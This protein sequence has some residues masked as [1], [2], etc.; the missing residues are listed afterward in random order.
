MTGALPRGSS[1]D[2]WWMELLWALPRPVPDSRLESLAGAA[3][4]AAGWCLAR[5]PAGVSVTAWVATD[6]PERELGRLVGVVGGWLDRSLPG[7]RL[8]SL[9]ACTA[10]EAAA[11]LRR[12]VVPPLASVPDA[13]Q[14]ARALP[15]SVRDPAATTLQLLLRG[16]HVG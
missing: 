1:P 9:R 10:V 3:T 15:D 4:S 11:E 13:A 8:L 16:C 2:R 12:P 6:R 14:R 7:A 5:I